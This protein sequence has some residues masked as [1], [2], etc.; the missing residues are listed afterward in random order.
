MHAMRASGRTHGFAAE[1]A[2]LAERQHGVV[3]RGQLADLGLGRETIG[4][5]SRS[6]R[7]H[8]LHVGVY[9][10]GHRVLSRHGHWLAA[11]LHCGP[12]A[13]L[14]HRSA[15][16]LWQI[17]DFSG[18]EIDVSTPRRS[19]S[20]GAI[21]RHRL[22][23]PPD[24][25]SVEDGIAVTTVPRT[26]LDL[27][28]VSPAAVEPALRQAEYLR[29]H[30]RLSLHDLLGRHPGHRGCR[31]VRAALA[32]RAESSGQTASAFEERFLH[33]LDRYG[34]PRPQ[35]NAWLNLGPNRFKVDCLWPSPRLVAELDSW[36]AHGT[37]SAFRED[38]A[39]DRR[40]LAAGYRTTRIAWSQLEAEPDAIAADL[41]RLLRSA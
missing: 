33:F 17:R 20:A 38:K 21:R 5:W 1:V 11:V 28:A 8:R 31:A 35:L 19:H 41:R 22:V 14:S 40:L 27:A 6:G 16:A 30:D 18:S 39:R 4:R 24:E 2:A 13:V 34:L 12:G 26:I 32:R 25:V 29:L 3:T 36:A 23:L 15:A 10:V 9:A 7:L 37:R